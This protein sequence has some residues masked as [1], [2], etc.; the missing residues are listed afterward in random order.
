MSKY[1]SSCHTLEELKKEYKRLAMANHPD[2]GGDLRTMQEINA[3]YD[4]L[5]MDWKRG[6]VYEDGKATTAHGTVW[7][8]ETPEAYRDIVDAL[9]RMAGLVIEV[10]G[11]WLWIEGETKAHK[12]ELKALGC[13]W[14]KD[15]IKWYWRPYT[16]TGYHRGRTW[17]MDRIR[18][19]YGSDVLTGR[20]RDD[21]QQMTMQ[22]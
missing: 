15:K 12:E 6:A 13:R 8:D 4:N 11:A 18:G 7:E 10:C 3:E 9:L 22:A 16:S 1:F 19:T 21:G 20:S 17:S 14:S 2:R 5:F